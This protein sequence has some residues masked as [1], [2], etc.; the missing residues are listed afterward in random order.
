MPLLI[1][2][3]ASALYLLD[4]LIVGIFIN[5]ASFMWVGFAVWTVFYKAS[6]Q[7]RFKG[8]LGIIIGFFCAIIM[9]LITNSFT[10]NIATVSVSCLLGVF[11]MN[12]LIM[13]F[14]HLKKF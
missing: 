6:I 5:G 4:A 10:L 2:F 8:L 9:M 14:D 1:A 7:D 3:I 11:V 13:T 12:G